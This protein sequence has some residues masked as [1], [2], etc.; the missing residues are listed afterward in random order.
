[1]S[2]KNFV[3]GVGILVVFALV[4]WQGVEAFYPSPDWEDYCDERR[5]KIP[6][7][8]VERTELTC[9]NE[10]GLWKDGY[11]D[12]YA[13][14]Q[15]EYDD[16]R[17]AHARVVFYVGIVVG[18]LAL[19]AGLAWLSVEPVGSALIGAGIWS[20]FWGTAINWTNFS[21]I[22]RFLLL[23]VAL[24]LLVWFTLRLNTKKKKKFW[25]KVFKV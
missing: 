13:E 4:L 25:K 5:P 15:S 18:I 14:C 22:W 19:F 21:S 11:C 23:L 16:A 17:D 10:G 20:I 6:G 1:M 24:V 2:F 9:V 12:Y 7:E 3:L 8:E